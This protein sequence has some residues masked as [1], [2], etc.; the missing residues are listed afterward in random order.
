MDYRGASKDGTYGSKNRNQSHWLKAAWPEKRESTWPADCS[1]AELP[2]SSMSICLPL[3]PDSRPSLSFLF[4]LFLLFTFLY[5][6]LSPLADL[7]ISKEARRAHA[8]AA[9][10]TFILGPCTKLI[11]GGESFH[12]NSSENAFFVMRR[13]NALVPN[14]FPRQNRDASSDR[15]KA[16]RPRVPSLLWSLNLAKG[17]GEERPVRFFP[18]NYTRSYPQCGEPRVTTTAPFR[19]GGPTLV[20]VL[21]IVRGS[22]RGLIKDEIK[23]RATSSTVSP[24]YLYAYRKQRW[25]LIS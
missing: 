20:L 25:K 14:S 15:S 5:L 16:T 9:A 19:R 11:R 10:A 8:L 4:Y 1:R 7:F 12:V 13:G 24:P 22:V 3:P 2:G 6:L 18:R 17:R 21:S 23:T